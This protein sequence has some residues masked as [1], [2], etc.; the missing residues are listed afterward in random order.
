M[1]DTDLYRE[2]WQ[3]ISKNKWRSTITAFGVFWGIFMLVT[4]AGVGNGL[5]RGI[6][7]QFEGF[8]TNAAFMWTENTSVPYKGFK[9]GRSW[10]LDNSDM[11]ALRSN[12]PEIEYLVPRLQ[13]WRQRSTNNIVYKDQY[14][15]FQIQGDYPEL[16]KVEPLK[17]AKGRFL[18]SIDIQQNRKVCVIGSR[19]AEVL[20]KNDEDP[21]GK[22]IRVSGVY[23]KVIGVTSPEGNIQIG[24]DKKESVHIP[25]TTVQTAFNYGDIV[26]FF[27]FT[28]KQQIS[29]ADVE[30]QVTEMLKKRHD[31]SPEDLSAVG[32]VNIERQFKMM[33]YLFIGIRALIYLVGLGTLLAGVIGISNIM[34]VIVKERTQEI[35]IKRALGATPFNIIRQIVLE[36]IFLTVTAGYI[37][38]MLGIL[39]NEIIGKA[40]TGTA[41]EVFLDPGIDL[42]MGIQSLIILV[43]AGAL[44]GMLPASRAVKVKP[45]DAIREE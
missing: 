40:L 7:K 8:A 31:I 20:F 6:S 43:F 2:V 30:N 12:I 11:E 10:N 19:V 15:T 5:E 26:H 38:M 28:A 41:S 34:L 16:A 3:A 29:V 1:F 33:S 13:A 22:Y 25:F 32:H 39:L 18:N 23:F 36:S 27:S 9:K 45:I 44:A 42:Q 17:M 21:V 35:G 24:Y 37:G 4:L 14:G